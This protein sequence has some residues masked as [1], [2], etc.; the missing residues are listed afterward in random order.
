MTATLRV[1]TEDDAVAIAAIYAPIV[2][3]TAISFEIVVPTAD[4]MAG[5]LR[6]TLP[7]YPWLVCAADAG[8]LAFA[9]AGTHRERAAYRWSVD[10]SVYVGVSGRRTGAGRGLY[11][12]LLR[13]LALQGYYQAFAG[14]S[15]PNP[16]SVD[17][18]EAMGFTPIGLYHSVGFK[19]GRWHDVGWWQRALQPPRDNPAPPVAFERLRDSSDVGGALAAGQKCLRL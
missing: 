13:I 12:A 9:Y 16:A 8:I 11:T 2:R 10:V 18:H 14:I 19:L 5:R 15:L 17:F 3:D 7:R 6:M 4:E 1:A